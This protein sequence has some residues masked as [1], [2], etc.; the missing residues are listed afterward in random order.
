MKKVMVMVLAV[1]AAGAF[2]AGCGGGNTAGNA[3]PA[4]ITR[5]EPKGDYKGKKMPE[6]ANA[7]AAANTWKANCASCHGEGAAGDGS[8]GSGL[9]PKPTDLTAAAFQ[10]AVGD[11]YLFWRISEGNPDMM[12]GNTSGMRGFSSEI[13]E[14]DRWNL[15]KFIR[16]K[17]K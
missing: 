2:V 15:V 9:N 6:T 1:A 13:K 12:F 7:E 4:K 16:S 5:P 17:K 8:L 10:D 11:D 14:E 3:A